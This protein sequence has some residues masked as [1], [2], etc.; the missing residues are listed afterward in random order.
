MVLATN[1]TI[2][3]APNTYNSTE[4]MLLT[5]ELLNRLNARER[6]AYSKMRCG[7]K[8][9]RYTDFSIPRAV[10]TGLKSPD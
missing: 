3:L 2:S 5:K 7:C 6:V 4:I 10:L 9:I 8:W 1:R